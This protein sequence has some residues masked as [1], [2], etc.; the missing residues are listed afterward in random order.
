MS[1]KVATVLAVILSVVILG[2]Y[3]ALLCGFGNAV[4]GVLA[5]LSGFMMLLDLSLICGVMGGSYKE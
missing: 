3:I 1:K 2:T 4:V 5:M